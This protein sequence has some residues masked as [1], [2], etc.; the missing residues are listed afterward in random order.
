MSRTSELGIF[1]RISTFQ[2][3]YFFHH[4]CW[5]LVG[6]YVRHFV[7]TVGA[8]TRHRH[9]PSA[10]PMSTYSPFSSPFLFSHSFSFLK[11]FLLFSFLLFFLF[12][13]LSYFPFL[14]LF[15]LFPFIFFIPTMA[16]WYRRPD[17]HT[18]ATARP[19]KQ[20][21]CMGTPVTLT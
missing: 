1:V 17:G 14:S 19:K 6:L 8:D 16:R 4:F 5:Y 20:R 13:F 11:A 18:D 2:N 9:R 3:C 21:T 7:G 15:L 10:P 12:F